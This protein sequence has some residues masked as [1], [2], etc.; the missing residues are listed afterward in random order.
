MAL[1][2]PKRKQRTPEQ[3]IGKDALLALIFEGYHVS[4][5]EDVWFKPM[6][7]DTIKG[8]VT[9]SY[10]WSGG[11]SGGFTTPSDVAERK[12]T[13]SAQAVIFHAMSDG[14]AKLVLT[15]KKKT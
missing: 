14:E 7:G 9:W 3:I 5:F 12:I 15:A 1:V 8:N 4:P 10:E 11:P 2:K 13:E 6:C